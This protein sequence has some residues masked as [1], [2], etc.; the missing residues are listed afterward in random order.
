MSQGYNWLPTKR[1]AQLAMAN[2]WITVLETQSITW[3]IPAED[4]TELQHLIADAE[5]TLKVAMSNDRTPLI[6]SKCRVAFDALVKKMRF[7]KSRYFLSPPLDDSDFISLDLKPRESNPTPV[8]PPTT[9]AEADI[10][11][12]GVHLL[13]LH[14]H[15]VK[16]SVS[17]SRRSD[18]AFHIWYGIMPPGGAT[19]E[20]ATGV[21]RELIKAPVS[22]EELP[23]SRL[24]HR[25]KELFDFAAEDS[26]KM[27]YFCIRYENA[28]G[29]PGPWGPLI[30]SVIP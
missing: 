14:L 25:K 23:H 7:T 2:N 29:E 11:R 4:I 8:P 30:Q 20:R 6:T 15:S 16:G 19:I 1:E 27:V 10:S 21:K 13:E 12:P 22:G 17:D 5:S 18:Y 26:G 9:Q 3:D 24:T 28:K